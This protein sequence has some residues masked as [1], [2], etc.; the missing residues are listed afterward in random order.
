MLNRKSKLGHLALFTLLGLGSLPTFG[1]E[2]DIV[3]PPVSSVSFHIFGSDVSGMA[4]M[5]FGLLV[6]VG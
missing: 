2:A 4:I 1:S 6:C 5:V 3:I